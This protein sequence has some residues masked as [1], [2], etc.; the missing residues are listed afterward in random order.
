MNTL[1]FH[2]SCNGPEDDVYRPCFECEGFSAR[3]VYGEYAKNFIQYNY[4][5]RQSGEN[6]QATQQSSR[7]ICNLGV[8][9]QRV[10]CKLRVSRGMQL[11]S[12]SYERTQEFVQSEQYLS[13]EDIDLIFRYLSSF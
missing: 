6:F 2:F 11:R 7:V 9:G 10:D 4:T 3:K 8:G 1:L 13:Q 5:S 12:Q